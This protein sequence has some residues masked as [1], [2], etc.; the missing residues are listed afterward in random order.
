MSRLLLVLALAFTPVVA[1]ATPP[2]DSV[3]FRL[4]E[5]QWSHR[6]LFV[7]AAT[8][9]S[10][11]FTRQADAFEGHDAGFQ[12]RDL[13]LLT[14]VGAEQGTVRSRP[15][16]EPRPLTEEAA[17]RLRDRF[18]V[19]PEAFRVVLVGKDGTEKRRDAEPVSPRSV[20]DTIDAMPMRQREMRKSGGE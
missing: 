20:F 12:D 18:G 19:P 7:F 9:T 4:E 14:V 16:T 17:R 3:D 2:A 8:D 13:L 1:M 6:L 10:E 5:H 15:D 11:A